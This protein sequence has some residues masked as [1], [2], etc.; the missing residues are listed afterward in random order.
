MK[1]LDA[2]GIPVAVTCRVLE[3]ARQPCDRWQAHPITEAETRR[4]YRADALS[5][6]HGQPSKPE[7]IF[8]MS[9]SF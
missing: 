1:E 7:Y 3:L 4:T 9:G 5:D 8:A 2:D 6:A